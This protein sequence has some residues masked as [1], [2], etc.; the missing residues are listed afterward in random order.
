M[1]EIIIGVA[2]FLA[3]SFVFLWACV[4]IAQWIERL[5]QRMKAKIPGDPDRW[6]C[7]SCKAVFEKTPYMKSMSRE[8]EARVIVLASQNPRCPA[9]QAE[10]DGQKMLDGRYDLRSSQGAKQ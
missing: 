8:P 7:P 5:G 1:G 9:C 3:A 4:S 10:L 6:V 2:V